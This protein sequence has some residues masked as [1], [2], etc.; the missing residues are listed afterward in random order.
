MQIDE[1]KKQDIPLLTSLTKKIWYLDDVT[2]EIIYEKSFGDPYYQPDYNW[3]ARE[4]DTVVGFLS[5]AYREYEKGKIGYIKLMGV[6]PSWRRKS[7]GKSLLMKFEEIIIQK[8]ATE[9]RVMDVPLNYFMPGLDPRYTEGVVFLQKNGFEKVGE[10]INMDVDLYKVDLDTSDDE[11]KLAKE[12]IIIRRAEHSDYNQIIKFIETEWK[13]WNYEVT[14]TFENKPV[15]LHIALFENKVVA[16]SAYYGNNKGLPW[17]GP[18]GTD[19]AMRGKKLGE[20]LLKRCLADQK[21]DG[22]SHSIIPWVG[23]VGFYLKAV[24]AHISRVFWTFRK[25]L[26]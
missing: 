15:S 4:N 16:F 10:N 6:S 2:E 21:A 3:I 9:L 20:I 8:G 14:R 11:K 24:N 5:G 13:L 26:T 19:K 22:F 7:I 17:F 18:M 12:G 23:P 1:L 25:S